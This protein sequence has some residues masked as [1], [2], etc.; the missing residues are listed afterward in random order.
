MQK[1]PWNSYAAAL[2]RP[3]VALVIALALGAVII[4]LAQKNIT[5]PI[6]A[7]SSLFRGAFGDS[8]A[9][10]NTLVRA[11]PLLLT[12]IAV[13]VA[14]AAGLFNIG[15]EGQLSVGG[16]AAAVVGV[17]GKGLLPGP[18]LLLSSLLAGMLTGAAWG[19]LPAYL[20]VKRGAHEVITAILLNYIAQ[21]TTRYLATGPLR[22]P[23]GTAA[24]TAEVGATLSRLS[25]NYDVH[26]GL[27][28]AVVA[29]ALVAFAL[30]RT[31]WGYET[32]AVGEGPG[33]AEA[34]GISVARVQINAMLLSGAL[35]GLAGAVVIL[36]EVPFKRFPS[37]FYGAGY[38]FDGLAAALLAG[39][40]AWAIFPA[41]LL[42]GGLASGAEQMTFD[43]G[44]PKQIVSVVQAI[45]ILAVGVRIVIRSRTK[46]TVLSKPDATAIP[47]AIAAPEPGS[48]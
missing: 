31:V 42:F 17:Y 21:N 39:G 34:A 46:K 30:R 22:E 36:G 12:G 10:A 35:A 28:I 29:V 37:D 5:A 2:G 47:A 40:S 13:F 20:K 7:Y 48:V 19:F 25:P 44:T 26:T 1:R 11:M 32:R 24:Q 6:A 9:W 33:A 8:T 15:A 38:G 41:A 3:V 14:L 45:L 16:L 23:G 4:A 18:I 27:L 43:V